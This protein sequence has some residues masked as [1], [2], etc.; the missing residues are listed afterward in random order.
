MAVPGAMQGVS[1]PRS[2]PPRDLRRPRD[3]GLNRVA[4]SV[5]RCGRSRSGR[6]SN[7]KSSQAWNVASVP[8]C[9]SDPADDL[10]DHRASSPSKRGA[11]ASLG[12]ERIERP[13]D[14]PVSAQCARPASVRCNG[15]KPLKRWSARF[16]CRGS[17]S[18]RACA[19]S[20]PTRSVGSPLKQLRGCRTRWP[21]DECG[22][23]AA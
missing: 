21:F 3:R 19:L 10:C 8:S 15:C 11:S 13:N 6:C 20:W 16:N 4:R 14:P 17:V 9:S 12:Q 18:V 23:S 5:E 2:G 1:D 7:W 22:E